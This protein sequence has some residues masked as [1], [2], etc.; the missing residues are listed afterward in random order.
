MTR[1]EFLSASAAF[2]ATGPYAAFARPDAKPLMRLGMISDVHLVLKDSGKGL[3]N[4]LCFEPSLRYFDSRK[5]DGVLI[6]GD[7]TDF[8]TVS[9]LKHFAAIWDKVFPGGRRSD[10]GPIK[11]LHIFGDHD[12]GGYMHKYSWAPKDEVESGIIPEQDV[13]ALWKEC[14]RE[15]WAPIQVKECCGY[16]FVLA[17]HPRHTKE[18]DH[19]NSI[20]GLADFL[21]KM[22]PDPKKPF[23]LVQHRI[24][25]NTMFLP[26]CGGWESGKTTE[27]LKRY[28]N[29]I[30]VCGHG[31]Y[32]AVDEL[33]LWQGEFTALQVPSINYCDTRPGRENGYT[34]A[35]KNMLMPRGEIRRSWQGYFGTMYPD[36][37]VVERRD[38]LNGMQLAPD[39]TIPLPSPDGSMRA[40][41]RAKRT[42]PPQFAEGAKV[43]ISERTVVNHSKKSTDA[44]IV[45]FPAA[46][47][48]AATP[49]AFDYAVTARGLDGRV[50]AEKFAF[51]KGQFWADAKDVRPVECAFAKSDLPVDW[52]MS[53][54][55]AAAPRDSFGRRGSE[56]GG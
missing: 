33:A 54:K 35:D 45:S 26:D 28:P 47:A 50:I 42:L 13:A 14:F 19:G 52:R 5:A 18:S 8:G 22:D 53:V 29:A 36:R 10:G 56:I 11:L 20:P 15:E 39:W 6:A 17:H 2:A 55:F 48:T 51:S 23:F 21:A 40:E 46:H 12:M 7:L 37:F 1:K 41:A 27:A 30:A 3:Q 32:N 16:R 38:F 31:H 4:C 44:V 43:S 25:R 9:C 24:F 34:G 49:R